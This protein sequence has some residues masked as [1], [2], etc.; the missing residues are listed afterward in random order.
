MTLLWC[1]GFCC[2][3]I[4]VDEE[5]RRAF[6]TRLRRAIEHAGLNDQQAAMYMGLTP[7][8]WSDQCAGRENISFSRLM[9]LPAAVHRWH[10]LLLVQDLGLPMEVRRAARVAMAVSGAKRMARIQKLRAEEESEIA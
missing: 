8:R 10:G 4:S 9:L 7:S 2:F 6:V 3:L 5:M 1:M